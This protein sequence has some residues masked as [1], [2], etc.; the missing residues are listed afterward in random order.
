MLANLD[1]TKE[2]DYLL[3]LTHWNLTYADS[4]YSMLEV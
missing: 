4:D 3:N 1:K 2:K